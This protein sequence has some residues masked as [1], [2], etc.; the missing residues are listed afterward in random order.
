MAHVVIIFIGT[1]LGTF[2][3]TLSIFVGWY[4]YQRT[5]KRRTHYNIVMGV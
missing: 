4:L 3:I 1:F 2:S 5:V